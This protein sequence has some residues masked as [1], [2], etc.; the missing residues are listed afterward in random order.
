MDI[1]ENDLLSTNTFIRNPN[2]QNEISEDVNEEY[3]NFFRERQTSLEEQEDDSLLSNTN[4]FN[5]DNTSLNSKINK[6]I[7]FKE[8]I[9]TISIDSRD[10]NMIEYPKPNHFDIF[11]GKTFNFIK[12]I[13][14]TSVE[15]PNTNA[16]INSSN[17]R[18]Y[19]IDKEDIDRDII[20]SITG[21]YPIY[22]VE[23]RIGSYLSDSLG[24]E[25]ASK[26]N[27]IKRRNG[28]S[29]FHFFDINLDNETDIVS[30][31]SLT[32]TQL[33]N[34]PIDTLSGTGTIKVRAQN[35]GFKTGDLVYILGCKTI[36]GISSTVL[37]GSFNIIVINDTFFQYEINVNAADTSTGGGNTVKIGREAPFQFLFGNYP[38]T[39]APNIGFPLENSSEKINTF[40]KSIKQFYQV[41]IILDSPQNFS[42]GDLCTINVSNTTPSVDGVRIITQIINATTFLISVNT[43]LNFPSFN[44]GVITVNTIIFNVLSFSNYSIDS[45]LIET[46][47]NH[48]YISSD[49]NSFFNISNTKS[50]PV[51]EGSYKITS[52]YSNTQFIIAGTLV[53]ESIVTVPGMG[54]YLPRHNPITSKITSI[55]NVVKNGVNTTIYCSEQ[56]LLKIGQDIMV[57]GLITS[58]SITNDTVRVI[59]IINSTSFIISFR[60][61]SFD[62]TT[63]EIANF[64]TNVLVL[65]YPNHGFNQLSSIYNGTTGLVFVDTLLPHSL[66]NGS[67]IRISS[68]NSV[69]KI[70]GSYLVNVIDADTFSIAAPY[71]TTIGTF[72]IIG[73]NSN[74]SL[75]SVTSIGGVDSTIINN[76]PFSVLDILDINTFTFAVGNAYSNKSEKG[77]GDNVFISSLR[78]GFAA[79]QT[80]TKNNLLN[81]SINLQGENYSLLCCKQLSNII[82]TGP[83]KDIFARVTLDQSAGNVVFNF[84][85][86][87]KTFDLSPLVK[88]NNLTL[89]VK[90]HDDTLY[91][92]ND[93][94]YSIALEI[95]ELISTSDSFNISSKYQAQIDD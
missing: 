66:I 34:N 65:S 44:S 41:Q 81:R 51:L 38:N 6:R 29:E 13:K 89:S 70:D 62:I 23:L 37:N 60:M 11:L 1:D 24:R 91:E 5:P 49:I 71:I 27:S 73:K 39:I 3:V 18:L 54:G 36:S 85:S 79:L 53:G 90:N 86:N 63:L 48:N 26:M 28:T 58:P 59:G 82:N 50:T 74:F 83:V 80:N 95:T 16:V 78:H 2:L 7:D 30:F 10:R 32:L 21:Y 17:N 87:P 8:V 69:P 15:F 4:R 35:H 64:G 14:L 56:H 43:P 9:S 67:L 19:W 47:Y 52:I 42:V 12:Q 92:F 40:I 84:L 25:M 45:I 75:Y 94:D 72:G 93:L 61:D 20:D 46:F 22:N 77:G 31:I 55:T 68:S 57:H 88:L 76:N 33:I